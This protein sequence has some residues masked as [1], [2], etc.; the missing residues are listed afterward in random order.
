M[1]I[2]RRCKMKKFI[3]HLIYKTTGTPSFIRR[4][5]WRRMLEYL[6]PKEGERILDIACGGGELSLKVAECGC[7]VSGIDISGGCD[8]TCETS[9]RARGDYMRVCGWKYIRANLLG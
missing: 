3:G 6:D 8:R 2:I 4:I 9:C 1:N 7:E 5:E